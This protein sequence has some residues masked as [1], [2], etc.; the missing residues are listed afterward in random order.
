MHVLALDAELLL[1]GCRSLKD[2]RA[3]LRPLVEQ[4]RRRHSVSVA[5]VGHQDTWQRCRLGVALVAATVG[6][7][8]SLADDIERTVWR[9][10]GVEVLSV[11]RHW[12]ELT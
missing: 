8:E 6:T 3:A 11:E 9:H 7:A 12:L 2:K 1:P 5:E 4:L 10:A